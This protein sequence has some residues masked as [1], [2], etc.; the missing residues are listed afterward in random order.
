MSVSKVDVNPQLRVGEITCDSNHWETIA[1]TL[2]GF[3]NGVIAHGLT[4]FQVPCLLLPSL[5]L[6]KT[7]E[8]GVHLLG[9]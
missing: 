4:I 8:T 1:T 5:E 9:V 7:H 2:K 3:L 6:L